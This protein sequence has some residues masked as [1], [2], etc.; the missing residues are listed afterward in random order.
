MGVS[1]IDSSSGSPPSGGLSSSGPGG[2]GPAPSPQPASPVP[3]Q[4]G[5]PVF[6][7]LSDI[8]GGTQGQG[9]GNS[10]D[11][12]VQTI[13]LGKGEGGPS[14]GEGGLTHL[15]TLNVG[16][17]YASAKQNSPETAQAA[18]P[19]TPGRA[20]YSISVPGSQTVSSPQPQ[21]SETGPAPN[22]DGVARSFSSN[23]RPAEPARS[24]EPQSFILKKKHF[25]IADGSHSM[26]AGS[27]GG[28][29]AASI[30]AS[31]TPSSGSPSSGP[32]ASG[33]SPSA[34]ARYVL[35]AHDVHDM[36]GTK[37]SIQISNSSG[38][39]LR[40]VELPPGASRTIVDLPPGDYTFTA[41]S[42]QRGPNPQMDNLDNFRLDI[43]QAGPSSGGGGSLGGSLGGSGGSPG[44]SS[45]GD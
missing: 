5:T 12:R 38:D 44:G 22:I 19:N 34:S 10:G 16:D 9:P 14:S 25:I 43:S 35:D 33:D 18:G 2:A 39:V 31:P 17:Q 32:A 13:P 36:G 28:Y 7:G 8:E 29:T 30:A 15:A 40:T 11:I 24:E 27:G 4:T 3:A 21:P 42:G 45:S 26:G 41:V 1:G 37:S 6:T 23:S 20:S